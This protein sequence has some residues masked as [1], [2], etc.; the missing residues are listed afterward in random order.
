MHIRELSEQLEHLQAE[1]AQI[2]ESGD[3]I[4]DARID[5]SKPG[6]VKVGENASIQHRLRIKG[7]PAKYLKAEQVAEYQAAINRGRQL[8]RLNREIAK[9]QQQLDRVKAIGVAL[10][11]IPAAHQEHK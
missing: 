3:I 2:K 10:G 6:G 9:L 8:K 1:V 11:F 5:S 7:K 4:T